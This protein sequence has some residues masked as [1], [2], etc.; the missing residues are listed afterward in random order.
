MTDYKD[1]STNVVVHGDAAF[2]TFT[3]TTG[4]NAGKEQKVCEFS[5]YHPNFKKTDNG[6]ERLDSTWYRVKYFGE[7]AQKISSFLKDGMTLEVRGQTYDREWIGKDG[8]T[9]IEKE[10]S[11]QGLGVSLSQPGLQAIDFQRPEK[12][13]KQEQSAQSPER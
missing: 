10:I 3:P 2:R 9:R 6:F 4:A 11:A 12:A 13:Q 7:S 8:K 1:I 5:A